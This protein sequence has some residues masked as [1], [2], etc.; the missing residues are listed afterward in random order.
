M[1]PLPSANFI[2]WYRRFRRFPIFRAVLR[3]D[4]VSTRSK[5]GFH[6]R[7]SGSGG[8]RDPRL[9]SVAKINTLETRLRVL[10][11]VL[12]SQEMTVGYLEA[13]GTPKVETFSRSTAPLVEVRDSQASNR[14][15]GYSPARILALRPG[16]LFVGRLLAAAD[17]S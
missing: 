7:L 17:L 15:D 5:G 11:W 2:H 1:S 12:D 8:P 10:G 16:K 4:G 3:V 6:F 14:T 13:S 9:L